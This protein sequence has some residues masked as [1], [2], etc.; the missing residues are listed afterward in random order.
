MQLGCHSIDLATE[1]EA[2]RVAAA[3]VYHQGT[4]SVESWRPE[5]SEPDAASVTL[6]SNSAA[7]KSLSCWLVLAAAVLWSSVAVISW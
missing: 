5:L 7:S 4:A 1:R 3:A 2:I 6:G